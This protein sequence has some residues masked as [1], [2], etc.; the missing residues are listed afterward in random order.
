MHDWCMN[1]RPLCDLHSAVGKLE[2]C[3]RGECAFWED[4]S[5]AF[6]DV[7]FEFE[8]RP[9]VA[10][11]LLGIR[12]ELEAARTGPQDLLPPGLRD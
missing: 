2:E 8:G 12:G 5:C 4:G 7:R 3:P 1:G 11:Y 10:R 9:D 6:E